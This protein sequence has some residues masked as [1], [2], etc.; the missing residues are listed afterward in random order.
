[1]RENFPC[2]FEDRQSRLSPYRDCG[3]GIL[4]EVG[5]V[6]FFEDGHVVP[7]RSPIRGKPVHFAFAPPQKFQRTGFV[8]GVLFIACASRFVPN[9]SRMIRDELA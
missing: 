2:Q 7:V 5:S 8:F 1:M 6:G 4:R 3:D 9:D